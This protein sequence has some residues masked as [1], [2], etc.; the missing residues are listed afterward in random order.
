MALRRRRNNQRDKKLRQPIAA[1]ATFS[2][3][4]PNMIRCDRKYRF[5]GPSRAED[6]ARV[7]SLAFAAMCLV[8]GL[9][10]AARAQDSQ[11]TQPQAMSVRMA[12]SAM[13]RWPNG[14][15]V[16]AAAPWVWDH[17][18]SV[19]LQGITAVWH[20]TGSSDDFNYIQS[21]VDPFLSADGS[22]IRTYDPMNFSV[23]DILLG[24]QLLL[25]Y[26]TTHDEK[27]HRAAALIR[28]QIAFQPRT[29][30]GG[31]WH[32]GRRPQQMSLDNLYMIEPFYAEYARTFHEPQDFADITKQ[33]VLTETHT[34]DPKT[35]LLYPSWDEALDQPWADKKTG[36]SPVF[37]SRAMGWNMMALV[38]TI[39]YFKPDDPGR[40]KL[41]AI[42]N[43]L[44]AA[45]VR[46][47]DPT[48][49]LWYQVTDKPQGKGNYLEASS[50]CMFAYSMAKAVR[51]GYLPARY[52][53]FAARAYAGVVKNFVKV[54]GNGAMAFTGVAKG[55]DL[56]PD[57]TRENAYAF[58]AS[59]PVNDDDP[60][61]A[62]VFMMASV[63]META[64]HSTQRA[65]RA[66]DPAGGRAERP[67]PVTP[68]N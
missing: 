48:T 57:Q 68:G 16:P 42:L 51:L 29:P 8:L 45:L 43:R 64:P 22:S 7:I 17:A 31:F 63:E 4:G 25:L 9:C 20:D 11:E 38:E 28:Q 66:A 40:A 53:E 33:F 24:R 55:S 52:S 58:Y 10:G 35:G 54:D 59:V 3:D 18:T 61:G 39:P 46:Y 26:A 14:R 23:D 56:T 60:R 44:A 65:M 41:L 30:E 2:G 13:K 37:W 49:G 1:A 15:I 21:A 47:Q 67:K 62:G 6:L 12:D 27:Y 34:R 32:I 36:A 50:S 19:L 5:A